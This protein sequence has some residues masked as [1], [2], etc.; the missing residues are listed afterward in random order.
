VKV[1]PTIAA[2]WNLVRAFNVDLAQLRDQKDDGDRIDVLQGLKEP[3]IDNLDR[4]CQ[5]AILSP[6][7][8]A[9]GH[10]VYDISFHVSD[11]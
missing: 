2:F 8:A 1:G 7:K 11:F 10:M 6:P 9:G 4:G 3:T 5:I